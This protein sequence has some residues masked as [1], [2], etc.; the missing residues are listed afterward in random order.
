M[1]KKNKKDKK[2]NKRK[3]EERAAA[4]PEKSGI[5]LDL[6]SV[7]IPPRPKPMKPA[8]IRALRESLNASQTLFARLLNVSSNAVESW[9]QGLREPR[10]ATLKLLHVARKNP[11]VLLNS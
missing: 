5:R 7:E 11:D 1:G 8:D 9:E 6:R 10:Q 4:A 3:E 2:K